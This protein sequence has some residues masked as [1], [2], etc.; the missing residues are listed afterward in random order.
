MCLSLAMLL[1]LAPLAR[2]QTGAESG[3]GY[4]DSALPTTMFRLRY[5]AMYDSNSPTRAE[6]MY[7]KYSIDVPPGPG[8]PKLESRIDTQVIAP[9]LEYAFLPRLSGFVEVPVLFVNPEINADATG[10]GDVSAGF[11]YAFLYTPTQVATFMLRATFPTGDAAEG[12]GTN[13][14]SLEPGL[15]FFRQLSDQFVIE[16]ELR[17]WAAIGGT[18]F[19]GNILRYGIGAS[20]RVYTDW[21]WVAPVT[22]FVG[23]TVLS[24]QEYVF[25]TETIH[26]A[27]G[28]T[29]VNAKI[30]V[31]TTVFT[32]YFN[33][34][35]FYAGYGRALT[36]DVW[37]K[38]VFRVELRVRF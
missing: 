4:I 8:L 26:H 35:D 32:E 29:I 12:L 5:D 23:W 14:Y 33:G 25:P 37:Y 31:R 38:N 27:A 9:Y 30:G 16:G 19:A 6:F 1:A 18:D 17:D 24:G 22:E 13:H 2:A 36:G 7:A 20:Y 21:G 11:K 28:E 34:M 3:V 15:L 10:L